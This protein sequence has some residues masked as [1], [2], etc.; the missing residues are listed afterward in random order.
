MPVAKHQQARILIVEDEPMIALTLQD[1]LD[2]AGFKVACVAAKL[3]KALALIESAGCDAAIVD[4]NLDGVSASPVALA[5]AA[6]G[7]PFIVLS[8]YSPEQLR[9]VFPATVFMKK[10]CRPDKIIQA[11]ESIVYKQ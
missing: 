5:L 10:P 8:G 4:A 9:G 3:G 6:R 2:E 11:L 1:L 7:L